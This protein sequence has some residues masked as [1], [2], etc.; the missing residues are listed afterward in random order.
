MKTI[1][2]IV[3]ISLG[4]ISARPDSYQIVERGADYKVL[5]K[6]TLEHGTNRLHRYVE[7][8]TGMN[9]T[10]AAGRWLEAK[11]QITILPTGGAVA[12]QGRHQ[13]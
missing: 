2:S 10:N 5:Q 4:V 6:T 13:V 12:V 7:L 8:A 1:I 3:L 9:Y 11:E